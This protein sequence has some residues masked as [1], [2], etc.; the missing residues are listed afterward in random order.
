MSPSPVQLLP[1][2]LDLLHKYSIFVKVSKTMVAV[3]GSASYGYTK[4]T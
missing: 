2:Q 1:G 3:Y 4:C